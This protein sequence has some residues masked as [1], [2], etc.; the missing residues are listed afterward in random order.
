MCGCDL[1]TGTL[2]IAIL[3]LI[4]SVGWTL[5]SIYI[6][7]TAD[8]I[9][10][11]ASA[12]GAEAAVMRRLCTANK[13]ENEKE[14]YRTVIY[15]VSSTLLVFNGFFIFFSSLL[16][17]GARNE[18]KSM[19]LPWIFAL[20]LPQMWLLFMFY[21]LFLRGIFPEAI[22]FIWACPLGEGDSYCSIVKVASYTIA[23]VFG[24]AVEGYI[25]IGIY[26]YWEEL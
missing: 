11:S 12:N 1:K 15:V 19:I 14:C 2:L 21:F 17:H 23:F 8:N 9:V 16:L 5:V 10:E 25:F 24:L 26:S 3:N 4:G 6:L 22:G 20:V 18:K 13:F 7:A